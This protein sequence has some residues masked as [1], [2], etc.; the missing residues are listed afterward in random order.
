MDG[1]NANPPGLSQAGTYQP[2][3]QYLSG[4]ELQSP[5][6]NSSICFGE[7]GVW[8]RS[9]G[10]HVQISLPAGH[11]Y[12]SHHMALPP[13]AV[14][15]PTASPR[16]GRLFLLVLFTTLRAHRGQRNLRLQSG[17]ERALVTWLPERGAA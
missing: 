14:P 12:S 4:A 6:S 13:R 10:G 1:Q 15:G 2:C 16:V 17:R 3:G 11:H 9:A 8:T 7:S 5:G